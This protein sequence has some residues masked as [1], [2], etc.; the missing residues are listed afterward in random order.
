LNCDQDGCE[1]LRFIAYLWKKG[2]AKKQ[3]EVIQAWH[4]N[5]V[6]LPDDHPLFY[7]FTPRGMKPISKRLHYSTIWQIRKT[8]L[9]DCAKQ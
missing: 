7:P 5:V 3:A 9:A 2:G 4:D 6:G 8:F 1:T